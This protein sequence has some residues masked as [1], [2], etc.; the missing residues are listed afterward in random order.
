MRTLTTK[1]HYVYLAAAGRYE[2][3]LISNDTVVDWFPSQTEA[4]IEATIRDEFGPPSE[5]QADA[6]AV[7]G[8]T[9]VGTDEGRPGGDHSARVTMKRDGD[10]VVITDIQTISG[11]SGGG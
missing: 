8:E 1:K 10:A 2:V 11:G 9:F 3:R 7:D 4:A 5:P 6:L